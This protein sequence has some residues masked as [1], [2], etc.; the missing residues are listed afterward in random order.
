MSVVVREEVTGLERQV[1]RAQRVHAEAETLVTENEEFSELVFDLEGYAGMGEQAAR[2]LAMLDQHLPKDFWVTQLTGSW[3]FNEE[4]GVSRDRERPILQVGQVQEGTEKLSTQFNLMIEALR[5]DMVP[6][7][8]RGTVD[9]ARGHFSI[10]L[11]QFGAPVEV[12]EEEE[13]R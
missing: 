8:E 13:A 9:P 7:R 12:V 4:L 2:A 5:R 3:G 11:S 1:K 10:D 6:L